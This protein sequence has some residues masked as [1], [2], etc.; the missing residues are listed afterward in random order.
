MI[1]RREFLTASAA[2]TALSEAPAA[3]PLPGWYDRPMRWAQLAFVE[4][5]PGNYDPRFWLDYFHRIHADGA[6]LSAGGCIA[7]YPTQIPLHY[8][9]KWLGNRDPFGEMVTGCRSLEM[10]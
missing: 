7:F 3:P 6:C 4:D 10:N 5:D 2:L 8:R 1:N 9:S